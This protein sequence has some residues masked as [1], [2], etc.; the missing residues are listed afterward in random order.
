MIFRTSCPVFQA[1]TVL[2][3]KNDLSVRFQMCGNDLQEIHIRSLTLNVG[4]PVFKYPDQ[5]NIIIFFCQ[6]LLN[7]LEV[8]HQDLQ[9][10]LI[11]VAVSI[12]LTSFHGKVNAGDFF[13]FFAQSTRDRSASGTNLENLFLPCKRKPA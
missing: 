10:F 8:S 4:F 7:L 6:I 1:Q 12:D 5:G 3:G 9:V 11:S 2:N 13:C